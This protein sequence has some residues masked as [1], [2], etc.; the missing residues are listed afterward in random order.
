VADF[1]VSYAGQ[2]ERDHAA[3]AA[4]VASGR[5]QAKTGV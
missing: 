3:L 5:A 1:A 4:A 2:N